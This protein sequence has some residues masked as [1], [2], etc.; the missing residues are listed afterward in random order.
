ME[1]LSFEEVKRRQREQRARRQT[2]QETEALAPAPE[3]DEI[4]MTGLT[5]HHRGGGYYEVRNAG[6]N[7]VAESVSKAKAREMGAEV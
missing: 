2:T 1:Y 4:D 3:P 5:A 6:G 7:V